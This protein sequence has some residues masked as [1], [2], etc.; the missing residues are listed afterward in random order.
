MIFG[1]LGLI[2]ACGDS[3]LLDWG[4][5]PDQKYQELIENSVPPHEA[6]EPPAPPSQEE[7]EQK[8]Q[9]AFQYQFEPILKINLDKSRFS[10]EETARFNI[11]IMDPGA[12]NGEIPEFFATNES[13]VGTFSAQDLMSCESPLKVTDQSWFV[14]CSIDVSEIETDRRSILP[15]DLS[16]KAKSKSTQIESSTARVEFSITIEGIEQ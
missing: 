8:R 6:P 14:P 12:K 3:N 5:E 7:L 16:I 11:Y 15:V 10:A 9:K 13:K 4:S 1:S 2:T